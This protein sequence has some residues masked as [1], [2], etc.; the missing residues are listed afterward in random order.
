MFV[1]RYRSLDCCTVL[2]GKVLLHILLSCYNRTDTFPVTEFFLTTTIV[3]E[4]C[5]F[6]FVI[7]L[8]KLIEKLTCIFTICFHIIS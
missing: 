2:T 1:N 6:G 5:F 8:V 7:L 3:M 4:V